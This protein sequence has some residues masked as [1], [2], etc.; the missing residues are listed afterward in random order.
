MQTFL[1]TPLFYDKIYKNFYE[2]FMKLLYEVKD[3][4]YSTIKEV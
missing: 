4:K 1:K 3:N 2:V